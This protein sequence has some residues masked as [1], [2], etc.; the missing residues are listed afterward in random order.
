MRSKNKSALNKTEIL[1]QR[2]DLGGH[3]GNGTELPN[4][5]QQRSFYPQQMTVGDVAQS[6]LKSLERRRIKKHETSKSVH[7]AEGTE[8]RHGLT[9]LQLFLNNETLTPNLKTIQ[10]K[11]GKQQ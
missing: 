11:G 3:S 6:Q 8:Q 4:V 5:P 7:M 10:N 1:D 2:T 9:Q